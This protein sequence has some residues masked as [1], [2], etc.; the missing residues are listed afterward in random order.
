MNVPI[1][2]RISFCIQK[3]LLSDYNVVR[4]VEF[5]SLYKVKCFLLS[6][7]MVN[8]MLQSLAESRFDQIEKICLKGKMNLLWDYKELISITTSR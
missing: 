2:M 6:G 8:T 7:L 4:H 3:F 1:L 5:K